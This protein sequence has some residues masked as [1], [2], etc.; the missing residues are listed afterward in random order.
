MLLLFIALCS[1]ASW[2]QKRVQLHG[3][4]GN[5]SS[6]FWLED[7]KEKPQETG[8]CWGECGEEGTQERDFLMLLM[9]SW[10]HPKLCLCGSKQYIRDS[11]K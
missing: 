3:R 4:E 10:A 11:E 2:P 7:Q 9:S 1:P 6:A 5:K 8:M